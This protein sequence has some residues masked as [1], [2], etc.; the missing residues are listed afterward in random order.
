M[1][2]ILK[3][4]T[5]V[6]FMFAT[7]AGMAREPKLNLLTAGKAKSVVLTMEAS[8][9]GVQIKLMDSDLN[10]IYSEKVSEGLFS[11]KLNFKDLADGVYFL[12]AD[13]N[14][15]NYSYTIVLE[16]NNVKIVDADEDIKP[17]FR[18]T[19]NMILMNYLNLDKSKM[20]IKIYDA[21]GRTV[22][23]QEVIDEL[24]VE[25][26]FNFADAFPGVYVVT[27][28]SAGKTYT[29]EFVVN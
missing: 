13:D 9:V 17:F 15:K 26:A 25:K 14:L 20:A 21:E 28:K 24:I 22:F 4:T 12:S 8:S 18:K 7:V 29:E 5:V 16:K 19:N 1:K 23:S 10:V 27:V 6:A 11:K 2:N 3:I